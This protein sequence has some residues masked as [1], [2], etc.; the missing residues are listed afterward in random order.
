VATQDHAELPARL[1]LAR[2]DLPVGNVDLC[3]E[4]AQALDLVAARPLNSGTLRSSSSLSFMTM[5][6]SGP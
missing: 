2:Q 4:L 3:G 1:T 5:T 6:A